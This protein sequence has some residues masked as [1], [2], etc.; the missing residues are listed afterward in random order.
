MKKNDFEAWLNSNDFLGN[1]GVQIILSLLEA[2]WSGTG[3]YSVPTEYGIF[4]VYRSYENLQ[5]VRDET[6][7]DSIEDWIVEHGWE[8]KEGESKEA[9]EARWQEAVKATR[10]LINPLL[11]SGDNSAPGYYWGDFNDKDPHP[12]VLW[13]EGWFVVYLEE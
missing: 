7:A 4:E 2:N 1:E 11:T 3:V 9:E 5:E 13:G 10:P 6:D 12:D 8:V